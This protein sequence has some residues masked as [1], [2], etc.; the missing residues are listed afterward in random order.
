MSGSSGALMSAAPSFLQLL[1]ECG[2][3]AEVA[4]CYR[5]DKKPRLRFFCKPNPCLI[6]DTNIVAFKST[7]ALAILGLEGLRTD[8]VTFFINFDS[9]NNVV[10]NE[11][12]KSTFLWIQL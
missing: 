10:C 9:N 5:S 1:H 4:M 2:K 6:D 11:T 12:I 3:Y 7:T 8:L